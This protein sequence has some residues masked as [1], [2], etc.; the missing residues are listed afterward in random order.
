MTTTDT[1]IDQSTLERMA[2]A[3]S[4]FPAWL[5]REALEELLE[6]RQRAT[7]CKHC[8][9]EIERATDMA[10]YLEWQHAST[11]PEGSACWSG[12][13]CAEPA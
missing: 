10:P 8:G 4:Q 5:L 9:A 7:R 12:D 13:I 11:V 3:P 1:S 6:R 2:K